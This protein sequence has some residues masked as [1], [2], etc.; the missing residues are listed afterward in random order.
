MVDPSALH[1]SLGKIIRKVHITEI[2]MAVNAPF[3]G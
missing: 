3:E 2:H 1:P